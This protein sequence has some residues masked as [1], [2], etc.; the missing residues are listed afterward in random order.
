MNAEDGITV[1]GLHKETISSEMQLRNIFHETSDNRASH[2]LPVGGS[3]D[4]STAV[5]ELTL[6]QTEGSDGR[7]IIQSHA[8]LIIVDVPSMNPLVLGI[9]SIL[10]MSSV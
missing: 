8:R 2:T 9:Y 10:Y 6:H 1:Q 5:W 7:G 4:T 3:I